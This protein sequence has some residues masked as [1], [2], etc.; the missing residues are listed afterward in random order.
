MKTSL[1]EDKIYAVTTKA[2]SEVPD[3]RLQRTLI[4]QI[5]MKH[6]RKIEAYE[7]E[8]GHC[9][10]SFYYEDEVLVR[11]MAKQRGLQH[12]GKLQKDRE[13]VLHDIGFVW[14]KVEDDDEMWGTVS[15][16]SQATT[17]YMIDSYTVKSEAYS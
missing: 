15:Y 1:N 2:D 6:Y 11:W 8:N 4:H 16:P 17:E 3:V 9:N 5:W 7:K 14:I 10:I 13:Q 12:N